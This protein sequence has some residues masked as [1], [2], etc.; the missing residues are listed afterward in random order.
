VFNWLKTATE[1]KRDDYHKLY[2]KLGDAI[3]EHDE[4]VS[5]ASSAHSSYVGTVPNL[6]NTKIPSNDFE[7]SR[8]KLNSE[9]LDYFQQDKDKRSSLVSAKNQAYE[10]YIHYKNLA[11]REAEEK[12]RREREEREARKRKNS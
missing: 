3:A 9:L 4:K 5:E 6:S 8:E 1:I 12:A 2:Q 11:I 10:R 7:V